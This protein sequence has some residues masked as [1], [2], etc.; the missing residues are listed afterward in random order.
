[1]THSTPVQMP[2]PNAGS[3]AV[4]LESGTRRAVE[5][6]IAEIPDADNAQQHNQRCERDVVC[7]RH[8]ERTETRAGVVLRIGDA[9][10]VQMEHDRVAAAV[11]I[12]VSERHEDLTG[13]RTA[14]AWSRA[15]QR[16]LRCWNAHVVAV[17]REHE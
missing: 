11:P 12:R 1:M 14:S 4:G 2:C 13:G 8:A 9:V 5:T 10:A 16:G 15:E 3:N 17:R 6:T 7:R